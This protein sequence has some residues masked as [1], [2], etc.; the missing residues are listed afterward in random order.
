MRAAAAALCA[1]A[2]LALGAPAAGAAGRCGP[3]PWCDTSLSP[4]RRAALLLGALTRD[5]KI[6]LLAGDEPFGVAGGPGT[7]TGTSNGVPRVGLPTTYYRDGPVG[8]RS[9]QATSMPSPISLA[10]SFDRRL[11]RRHGAVVGD[12]VKRKGN[13]VVFAPTTN[14]MRTPL[15]GRTFESYGE[16]PYLQSRMGV[17]W[18]RGAQAQGVIG[19]VKHYAVNN[20]EGAGATIPGSPLGAGAQGNRLTVDAR[21][22][23]RTLR[24]VYLPHFEAAVKEARV[25]SVMCAYNRVN[26]QYACENRHLLTDI[27][28]REWGF[29]GFVLADYG[30]AKNTGPQLRNGL[31]FEPWPGI[32]YSPIPVRA[33]LASGQAPAGSVDEHVRRILRTL[34][35]YGFFDRAAYPYDDGAIDRRGHAR[36][37]AEIEQ[38]GITLLKNDGVLPIQ[39]SRVRTLAVIGADADRFKSG[40]GS[41][42]VRPF[43]VTTPR[44]G[45]ERRAGSRMRVRYD[46]G[47]DPDQ[48]AA[49]AR[50]ADMAVVV[51]ADTA[52]EGADKPCMG[53]DCGSTEGGR[54][55]LIETVAAANRR[56]V[57]VL[58]TSA[59]VL[60]PWRGRVPGLVEM[61]Y[62]G[63]EGGTALARVLFGDVDPGGRLPATFPRR[64]AD[65]PTSGDP[66]AYPGVAERVVYKEGIFVGHRWFDAKGIEPAYA[67]GHGLSYTRFSYRN[68]RVRR[69][70]GGGAVVLADVRNT[71]RRTGSEVPQLYLGMPQARGVRQ[72]PRVLK[73][74]SKLRLS[75]GQRRTARFRLS[76]RDL[77]Y[78]DARAGRWRVARGCYAVLVGRSSRDIRLRGVLSRG[79]ARCPV[80]CQA[81]NGFRSVAARPRGRRVA[82]RFRRLTSRR[83]RV[84]VFLQ[85][86]GRRVLRAPRRV[87]RF[88]RL[89][90]FRWNGRQNLRG[91]GRRVVGGYYFARFRTAGPIG[92][93]D[94]RRIAFRRVRGRFVRRPPFQRRESCGFL[95]SFRL[96]GPAFGGR[97][98]RPLGIA[99]R[100]GRRAR[101]SVVVRRG[102]KVIRR[103]RARSRRAGRVHR[104]RLPSRRLRPGTYRVTVRAKAGRTR[105]RATLSSSRLR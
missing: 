54:D 65:L 102:R 39:P 50:S 64:E 67:F 100:T 72:P 94:T 27:L 41:S 99:Y 96:S 42:N 81:V 20:Q 75:P 73:G 43:A 60:T 74:F 4:D 58:E 9:G 85:T 44:Q 2:L 93:V 8:P 3:H 91:R 88:T 7:H 35:A 63:V 80:A 24:E 17:E 82:L 6:S 25:G 26:G 61:W 46:P 31:D 1:L 79:G 104:L 56:T 95:R 29:K 47:E 98:R 86:R 69:A 30:A 11:A 101:V 48:A 28:K 90:G 14:L 83:A 66:E 18:I 19:N 38:A 51:V 77:S 52:G 32:S 87:A 49:V 53:L 45:I 21:V 37:A 68:L 55:E 34:F 71:G 92:G 78:Y 15:G 16:D 62:P 57:V 23:E 70:R 33:A 103:Y 76:P 5:E 22:D 97:T 84:D 105:A 13:D 89:R 10:A 36:A 40:G 12:E 59:P